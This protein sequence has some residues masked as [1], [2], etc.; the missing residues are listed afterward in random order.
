MTSLL[1]KCFLLLSLFTLAGQL[2]ASDELEEALILN[3]E[4]ESLQ[5]SARAMPVTTLQGS[6]FPA[7]GRREAKDNLEILYFGGGQ[8]D[9]V[10]TRTAAPK[11]AAP[12]ESAPQ[13]RNRAAPK[14]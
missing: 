7:P 2:L 12:K 13:R 6:Q 9:A 10:R 3:Q 14:N 1:Q 11:R 5:E 4:L 8:E